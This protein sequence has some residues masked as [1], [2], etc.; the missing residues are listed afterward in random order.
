MFVSI[1]IP[2]YNRAHSIAY[3]L[4]SFLTQNYPGENYEIIVCDNNSTDN[5][6]EVVLKYVEKYGE[7]RVRYMFEGRQ[8]VHY[9]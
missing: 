3:T 1:I 7:N 2:T 9:A 8:G 4:D 5:V 6:K